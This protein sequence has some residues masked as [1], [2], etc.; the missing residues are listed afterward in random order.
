MR[1]LLLASICLALTA[2]D[3]AAPATDAGTSN[4]D[5][6]GSALDAPSTADA[7]TADAPPSALVAECQA[8]A[9]TFRDNCAGSDARP[10]LWDAYASL[11]AT[12]NTQ[13]LVDSMNCLDRT[14][15][16][17]FSDPNE[18]LACL[19]TVHAAGRTAAV[20]AAFEAT[21]MACSG[22]DCGRVQAS[23]TAEILPYV[24]DADIAAFQS[25]RGSSCSFAE[26][27]T[28]CASVPSFAA[29]AACGG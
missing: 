12:G 25:C 16:R 6:P 9:T 13:L 27:L 22:V 21:C 17:S 11:C 2:C 28:S 4:P 18:G 10:C 7:P 23:A 15:C 19:E 20:N 8:L 26:F 29:F 24:S 5:A 3:P 14:T 1:S